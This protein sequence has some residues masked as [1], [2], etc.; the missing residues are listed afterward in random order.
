MAWIPSFGKG[1]LTAQVDVFNVFNSDAITEY[2]E[3]GDKNRASP[4]ASL[5]YGL[6]VNFQAPRSV[7]L[8]ITYDF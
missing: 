4:V 5:D 2:V 3:T 6:P 7:R 1:K 8:S